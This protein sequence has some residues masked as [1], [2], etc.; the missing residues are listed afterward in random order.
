M[1]RTFDK[2]NEDHYSN[3]ESTPN[4]KRIIYSKVSISTLSNEVVQ[5]EEE[6]ESS[7]QSIQIEES[8]LGVTP[9]PAG[10]KFYEI[11]DISS[12]HMLDP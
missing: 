5:D 1:D 7:I 8:L 10:M 11:F 12:P 4:T 6:V 3:L 9:S 2:K